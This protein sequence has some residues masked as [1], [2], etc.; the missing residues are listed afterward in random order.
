[1]TLNLLKIK[2]LRNILNFMV[3]VIK[4]YQ[5]AHDFINKLN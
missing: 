5:L 4:N 1:M 2:R 3:K